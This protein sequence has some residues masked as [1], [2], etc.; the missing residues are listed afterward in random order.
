MHYSINTYMLNLKRKKYLS[1]N[2][3]SLFSKKQ[4][5]IQHSDH[6]VDA[7]LWCLEYMRRYICIT[8]VAVLDHS[9]SGSWGI[10]EPVPWNWGTLLIFLLLNLLWSVLVSLRPPW[11]KLGS[12]GK[13]G[14]QLRN[15]FHKTGLSASLSGI[16]LMIDVRVP[17][18]LWWWQAWANGFEL[19]KKA[20]W[21][22]REEQVSK[23]HSSMAAASVSCLEFLSWL[24]SMMECDLRVVRW[25]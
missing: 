15:C 18:L 13:R 19:Y 24:P 3:C 9:V 20:V 10:L 12:L 2:V 14:S 7:E 23:Q 21:A 16:Y 6:T 4:L 17:N 5:I 25:K 1:E 22:S 8:Y 11:P